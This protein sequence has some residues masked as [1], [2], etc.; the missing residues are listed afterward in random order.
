MLEKLKASQDEMKNILGKDCH[1]YD[2][3]MATDYGLPI[4]EAAIRRAA[5][6]PASDFRN[7]MRFGIRWRRS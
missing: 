5:L 2:L 7:R 1:K 6:P 3:V 4:G